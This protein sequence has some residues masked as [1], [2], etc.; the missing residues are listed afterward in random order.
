MRDL[1]VILDGVSVSYV[2]LFVVQGSEGL[3][4]VV[5]TVGFL[6]DGSRESVEGDSSPVPFNRMRRRR[7]EGRKRGEACNA[8]SQLRIKKGRK[9]EKKEERKE[10]EKEKKKKKKLIGRLE[11]M[12]MGTTKKPENRSGR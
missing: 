5:T 8:Y 3:R 9:E 6:E 4:A 1:F 11:R 12:W 7:L 10:K 2:L